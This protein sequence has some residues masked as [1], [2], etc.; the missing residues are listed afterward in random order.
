MTI[1]RKLLQFG[2][3]V[4]GIATALLGA[5]LAFDPIVRA[6]FVGF[7]LLLS[8]AAGARVPYAF[9]LNERR[10]LQLRRELDQFIWLARE[11][12]S[13]ALEARRSS[14]G[15]AKF[16]DLQVAMQESVERMSMFAGRTDDE[17]LREQAELQPR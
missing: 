5:F 14:T 1:A 6:V 3:P 10:Y 4:V 16:R 12:N 9:L 2:L 11:L 13:A 8:F 15:E 7:G 17:L